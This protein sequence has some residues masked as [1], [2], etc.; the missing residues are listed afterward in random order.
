[1]VVGL[2]EGP[3]LL[4]ALVLADARRPEA[5]PAVAALAAQGLRL[6]LLSGDRQE[7]AAALAAES[8]DHQRARAAAPRPP[9]APSSGT[10]R[11]GARWWPSSATG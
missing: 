1:M 7:P 6:H 5:G 4:G 2:A 8:G 11:P 3:R 10:C 9:S